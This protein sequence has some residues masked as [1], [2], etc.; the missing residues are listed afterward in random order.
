M[1]M[2]E[3]NEMMGERLLLDINRLETAYE[4]KKQQIIFGLVC[5]IAGYFLK[6]YIDTGSVFQ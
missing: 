2:I 1:N 6:A 4:L 5:F 3:Q